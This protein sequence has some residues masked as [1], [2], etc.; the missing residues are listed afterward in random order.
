MKGMNGV[1]MNMGWSHYATVLLA[2]EVSVLN[3]YMKLVGGIIASVLA[4]YSIALKHIEIMKM[5]NK[6]ENN[7]K[8][9]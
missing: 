1:M 8:N 7:K 4:V 2:V 5:K 6:F 9:K 3:E